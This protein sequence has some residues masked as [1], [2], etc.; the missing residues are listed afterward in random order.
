MTMLLCVATLAAS[1]QGTVSA[2]A[3]DGP[4]K[5]PPVGQLSAAQGRPG[6]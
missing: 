1:T 5:E 2:S 6:P 4:G 3:M